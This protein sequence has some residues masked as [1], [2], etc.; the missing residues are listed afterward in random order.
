MTKK[1]TSTATR[2]ALPSEGGSTVLAKDGG[3]ISRS[4]TILPDPTQPGSTKAA[5]EEV[6][7]PSPTGL[8]PDSKET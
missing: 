3:V 5:L 7:K 1:P 2:P 4:R 8:E 6:S